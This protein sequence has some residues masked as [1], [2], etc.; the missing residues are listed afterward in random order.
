MTGRRNLYSHRILVGASALAGVLFLS[1]L[2]GCHK[3]EKWAFTGPRVYLIA[4]APDEDSDALDQIR[5]QL[6]KQ[7]INAQVYRPDNWLKI[8]VDI[9]ARP[10]EEVI[11]V[12]HGH[13]AFL[14]TQVARHYAQ[15][16]K[17][18]FIEAVFAIDA[19]NKDWPHNAHERGEKEPHLQ[20]MPTPV[21]HNTLQVWNCVQQ[22]PESPRWGGN[23]VSTRAS[24][25]A[26]NHPYYWYDDYW[27]RRPVTGQPIVEKLSGN[28]ITHETIDNDAALVQRIVKMCRREALSPYHYTPPEHHPDVE[29]K[30]KPEPTP[31]PKRKTA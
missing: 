27:D 11:L 21:G 15:R 2:A 17:T 22:N 12:G 26:L 23:L 29:K 7:D 31:R 25:I 28:D 20:P 30:A 18:K 24:N 4:G 3:P 10:D 16:H 5:D 9:D 8:V 6:H 13:G 14:A 1:A 19:F